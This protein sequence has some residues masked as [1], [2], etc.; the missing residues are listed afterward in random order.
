M[1]MRACWIA[2]VFIAAGCNLSQEGK[3][4]TSKAT[5]SAA[6][7]RSNPAAAVSTPTQ[8]APPRQPAAAPA[9]K[10][11]YEE[12]EGARFGGITVSVPRVRVGAVTVKAPGAAAAVPT[13]E[14]FLLISFA[15]ANDGTS[16][17]AYQHPSKDEI[18]V[19]DDAG[20]VFRNEDAPDLE[21]GGQIK[22]AEIPPNRS[23]ND[24]VA[25]DVT[26]LGAGSNRLLI[27]VPAARFNGPEGEIIKFSV[28]APK[29]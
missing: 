15:I 22:S 2:I 23:V 1:A 19:T 9:K 4:P 20:T 24:F 26:P 28:R 5:I 6:A 12:N 17:F 13:R 29:K 16:P 3:A 10:D 18:R 21:V 7:A 8:P 14:V 25:F 11:Y 27:E